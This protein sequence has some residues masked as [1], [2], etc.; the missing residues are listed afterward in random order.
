MP[1]TA[2]TPWPHRN[3]ATGSIDLDAL[4]DAVAA[5]IGLAVWSFRDRLDVAL[6]VAD[7][8]DV[9]DIGNPIEYS[10]DL[11]NAYWAQADDRP[12]PGDFAGWVDVLAS[13]WADGD[14]ECI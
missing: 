5:R 8:D 4:A 10:I 12:A 11:T 3:A 1:T 6:V 13:A 9:D 14:W 7:V 2:H